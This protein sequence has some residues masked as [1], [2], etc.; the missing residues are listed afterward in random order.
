MRYKDSNAKRCISGDGQGLWRT[1]S[2]AFKPPASVHRRKRWRSR[3]AAAE[4]AAEERIRGRLKTSRAHSSGPSRFNAMASISILDLM[5]SG[6]APG[7]SGAAVHA[8]GA[9]SGALRTGG[10]DWPLRR[11]ALRG[12]LALRLRPAPRRLQSAGSW[13]VICVASRPRG[14]GCHTR[15]W[16]CRTVGAGRGQRRRLGKGRTA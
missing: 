3:Y 6:A 12:S 4:A 9:N 2:R 5:P 14:R 15:P 13:E 10:H 16:P 8:L 1:G 11:P 7:P